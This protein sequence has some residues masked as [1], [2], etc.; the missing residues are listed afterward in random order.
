MLRYKIASNFAVFG[1]ISLMFG[2]MIEM[3]E[4]RTS[5]FGG[6]KNGTLSYAKVLNTVP[7]PQIPNANEFFDYS[8]PDISTASV[9]NVNPATNPARMGLMFGFSYELQKRVTLDVLYKQTISD[10]KYVPNEQIRKVYTQPYFR[11]ML[12]FKLFENT[13]ENNTVKSPEGF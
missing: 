4:K 1:G 13:R 3:E 6:Q 7:P 12:G 9:Q 11:V 10:M 8:T 2:N 5:Y